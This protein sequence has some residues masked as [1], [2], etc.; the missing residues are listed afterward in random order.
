LPVR[1]WG[2]R[3]LDLSLPQL[4]PN[5]PRCGREFAQA[6]TS[7]VNALGFEV[8][9]HVGDQDRQLNTSECVGTLKR[10]YRVSRLRHCPGL[11]LS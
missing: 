4:E 8:K 11:T 6:P 7:N 2:Q 10:K 3:R 5:C 9:V 1:F